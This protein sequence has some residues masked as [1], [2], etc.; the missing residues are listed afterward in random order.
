MKNLLIALLIAAAA[1]T[2]PA[3]GAEIATVTYTSTPLNPTTWEYDL[4]LDDT[5][6]TNVGTLWFAW[7]PGED[8]MPAQP[9]NVL[10]PANWTPTITGGGA[11][12]GY[13]VRWV[14]GGGSA[15]TP[16]NS[17]AG[18]S[19]DSATTPAQMAGLSAFFNNPPVTTATVYS[20]QPFSDPG[21]TLVATA[22]QTSTPEP[23]G[24]V[25]MTLGVAALGWKKTRARRRQAD[26]TEQR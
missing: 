26:G 23:A 20:G 10:N 4:T 22:A 5:G 16:G 6:T 24:L 25:L 13:A 17:V 7:V 15:I 18:F 12:D 19:F 8:F 11:G 14:A 9:S 2:A 21:F 3:F 1:C